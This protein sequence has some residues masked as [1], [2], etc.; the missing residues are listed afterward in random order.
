MKNHTLYELF[1]EQ[2][3]DMYGAEQQIIDSLPKL[4]KLA[5]LPDLK[6]ALNNHLKE[7]K[8]QVEKLE[9]VFSILNITPQ[10]VTCK[11][12]KGL[13]GEADEVVKKFTKSPTL[14][15]A[16]IA[17]AQKVEHYEMASYGTLR[18]FAKHLEFDRQVVNLLQEILDEEG[19]AD[20]KLTKI[21]T[22]TFFSSGVNAEAAQHVAHSG[23]H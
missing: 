23:K 7:T 19:A 2:L 14:D 10:E 21:A 15:A 1:I 5:S 8:G 11:A 18:S 6:D 3:K 22:G 16:I 17:A 9:T 20:K 13:L 12:M 4:I